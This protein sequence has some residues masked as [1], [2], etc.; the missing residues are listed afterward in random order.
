MTP[1][2][3]AQYSIRRMTPWL[4]LFITLPGA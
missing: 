4:W 3:S 2:H 1:P